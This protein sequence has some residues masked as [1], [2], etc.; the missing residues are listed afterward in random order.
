MSLKILHTSDWHLGKKLFK[1]ER[2]SEHHFFLDWL[3]FT[4]KEHQVD[5]LLIAGDIFDSVSPP[6][7][8]LKMYY[9]FLA[10]VSE[11]GVK[12]YIISG[13]HDSSGLL[14]SAKSILEDR[15]IFLSTKLE[16]NI[17]NHCEKIWSKDNS[18]YIRL[19]S[20]PYFRN[21]E[22]LGWV[23]SEKS[24][25][26]LNQ[27]QRVQ[28]I[29]TVL[30]D[31]ISS[32]PDDYET[33][34]PSILMAHH[35]FG[36]FIE[37][38]SEQALS[39]SGLD[40]IPAELV[41]DFDYVALG[42]IHKTQYISKNPVIIYPGSPIP[43]RFSE[44]NNKSISILTCS[45]DKIDH[46]LIPIP[47]SIEL[48]QLK[49][50]ELSLWSKL[51]QLIKSKSKVTYLE[52]IL[53]MSG[54]QSGLTD[55]I[56]EKLQGSNIELLSFTPQFESNQ[57]EKVSIKEV[58]SFNLEDLFREYYSTKFNNDNITKDLLNDFHDLLE[59]VRDEN[60]HS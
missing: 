36:S 44:S 12:T 35:S 23:K 17:E 31:F 49:T 6:H 13:N 2:I 54:P 5:A 11:L 25:I 16:D 51:E 34:Y 52:L 39:L 53:D 28:L 33:N 57:T 47:Y 60:T 46:E 29:T 21:Y 56:R 43:M 22:I 14:E 55:Q 18:F 32:W 59:E 42:H 58:K 24:L 20:L 26:D 27:E 50:N 3:I 37:A 1:K 48:V 45:K 40:S 10:K 38:G 7:S 8:A 9:D 30:K 4:I 19:K 15:N 41:K